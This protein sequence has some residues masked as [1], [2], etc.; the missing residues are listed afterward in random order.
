[1][2]DE[3]SSGFHPCG[4]NLL[5][6]ATESDG[7]IVFRCAAGLHAAIVPIR[8][9]DRVAGYVVGSQSVD[10]PLSKAELVALDLQIGRACRHQQKSRLELLQGLPVCSTERDRLDGAKELQVIA[11]EITQLCWYEQ[12]LL[13]I[14][15]TNA[16]MARL[17]FARDV[18]EATIECISEI[19]GEV[20]AALY[21][22]EKEGHL[23]RLAERINPDF[24]TYEII[25]PEEGRIGWVAANRRMLFA[26]D[27]HPCDIPPIERG[28][29]TNHT[30]KADITV[31]VFGEGDEQ[32]I[33][34][35]QLASR[36][37]TFQDS[38]KNLLQML[39]NLAGLHLKRVEDHA[40]ARAAESS[41]LRPVLQSLLQIGFEQIGFSSGDIGLLDLTGAELEICAAIGALQ[42][43]LPMTVSSS[44][45]VSGKVMSENRT[46]V[47]N[48]MRE[49]LDYNLLRDKYGEDTVYG[50][51]LRNI[52]CTAKT[53]LRIDGKVIGILCVHWGEPNQVP[54][55][56]VPALELLAE[57][58]G[59]IVDV[60]RNQ[61][62][63]WT[64]SFLRQR[65]SS[66]VEVQAAR[67]RLCQALSD[68]ALRLTG[69]KRASV[70]DYDPHR[71][72]LRIVATSGPGWTEEIRKRIKFLKDRTAGSRALRTKEPYVILDVKL[73][74]EF[75]ELFDDVR[76]HISVPIFFRNRVVG[77][78]SVDSDRL[79]AY[80]SMHIAR[81]E[82]LAVQFAEVLEHFALH[83]DEWLLELEH[84]MAETQ[85]LDELCNGALNRV[86]RLFGVRACSIY[87]RSP[88]AR[89]LRLVSA[90]PPRE[91]CSETYEFG[92]GLTGWV[93]KYRQVLR[94]RDARDPAERALYTPPPT[95]TSKSI[96]LVGY[97]KDRLTFLAAP[98]V[99]HE[100]L[101]GVLRLSVLEG[102]AEFTS[103][104]EGL[105]ARLCAALA[106][107]IQNNWLATGKE[108]AIAQL[109]ALNKLG[110]RLAATL[111]LDSVAKIVLEEGLPILDC[112]AGHV[113]I[114]DPNA[115]HLIL[116]AAAGINKEKVRPIRGLGKGISGRVFQS[117]R[118][119]YVRD[120][121]TDPKAKDIDLDDFDLQP[122]EL[123]NWMGS[124]T[125]YPLTV[126]GEPIGT[127]NV[128]WRN[129]QSLNRAE[130]LRLLKDIANRAAVAIKAAL[131]VAEIEGKL[132]RK[133]ESMSRL[134]DCGLRF[135]RTLDIDD[136]LQDILATAIHEFGASSGGL[137]IVSERGDEWIIR[138]ALDAAGNSIMSQ[139][140]RTLQKGDDLL[141]RVANG[142]EVKVIE[143][144]RG[145][146]VQEFRKSI[147]SQTH[148]QYL[149]GLSSLVIVPMWLRDRCKGLLFLGTIR[150][151]V[152]MP[153]TTEFLGML[154][155]YAA[156][157]IEN[158]ELYAERE[159]ELRLATPLAMMGTMLGS[160]EHV[161]RGGL[162]G[163]AGGLEALSVRPELKLIAPRVDQVRQSVMRLAEIVGDVSEFTGTAPA[164]DQDRLDV[165]RAVEKA[166]R[167]IRFGLSGEESRPDIRYEVTLAEICTVRGNR[168]Q[169]EQAFKLILGNAVQAMP[170][171]G[172][173]TIHTEPRPGEVVISFRDT[174]MGMDEH[175]LSKCQEP[176]YTTKEKQGGRGLGLSVVY[177]IV[178]R[179][180]GSVD[181][182][183]SPGDGTLVTLTFPRREDH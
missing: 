135:A 150:P 122:Q 124:V 16:R 126:Q 10:A 99:V 32:V 111:S 118:P 152:P 136:L 94:L 18:A 29:R 67:S 45:G 64:H 51:F 85:H 90:F 7:P 42:D 151:T 138:T 36:L 73:A 91:D 66:G 92:E 103:E 93:G 20:N 133:I 48:D 153:A 177:G 47:V 139:F 100:L 131:L 82:R 104:D 28:G 96:D 137:R 155:A 80:S 107:S 125:C 84:F 115:R 172:P 17:A 86:R 31:P 70:R 97:A 68:E 3:S 37:T 117:K 77:V 5:H 27:E 130:S 160:F 105:I 154:A 147:S 50:R 39:A 119:W 44:G 35:L 6:R 146:E 179:H 81:M 56:T 62:R 106:L 75:W 164:G 60:F 182:R 43:H 23:R 112:D 22:L 129:T 58:I 123:S 157:A 149:D 46:I 166:I 101:V 57:R 176:F 132:K 95:H 19:F 162:Q 178:R 181:I 180:G 9:G 127:I 61:E 167:Q 71:Q 120:L 41:A 89:V 54:A 8:V 113:R 49:D 72:L 13:L 59:A 140:D 169:L 34:V 116:I 65:L 76:S 110:S 98:L 108:R 2:I 21:I 145:A 159:K 165:N 38:H 171:G 88:G 144:L 87:L 142:R 25:H 55:R 11:N 102:D 53:P 109:K 141:S 14:E 33:G 30:L 83:Q 1:M 173:I 4:D 79:N 121:A 24:F 183:S 78:I 69:S 148:V 175:T 170:N 158:A 134:S 26:T 161:M 15:K 174:G 163:I 52:G 128:H 74:E 40:A 12:Q 114:F 156:V 63:S 143:D 168:V